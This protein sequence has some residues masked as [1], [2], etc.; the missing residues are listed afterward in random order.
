MI[1]AAKSEPDD[2]GGCRYRTNTPTLGL[3]KLRSCL[4]APTPDEHRPRSRD[5]RQR[6]AQRV[7][8]RGR[9][10]AVLDLMWGCLFD[11]CCLRG[12]QRSSFLP[13]RHI[14]VENGV[15]NQEYLSMFVSCSK[16]LIY[17]AMLEPGDSGHSRY[18]TNTLSLGLDKLT[19]NCSAPEPDDHR[20]GRGRRPSGRCAVCELV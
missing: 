8:R 2:P 10:R 12:R 15:W 1:Y 13:S 16:N 6:S 20:A 18:Q 7:A 9:G 17:A 5:E 11:I 19:G 4:N 3:V 14:H